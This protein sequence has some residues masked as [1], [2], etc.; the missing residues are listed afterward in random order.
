MKAESLQS[1]AEAP[2]LVE[3][4]LVLHCYAM[5]DNMPRCALELLKALAN[6]GSLAYPRCVSSEMRSTAKP[7]KEYEELNPC[8]ARLSL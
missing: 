7:L 1:R 6:G 8:D 5:L 4:R 2:V 3:E